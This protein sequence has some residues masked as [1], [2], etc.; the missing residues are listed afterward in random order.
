MAVT[1]L[2]GGLTPANGSDPRTFPAIWNA[3][4]DDIEQAETDI[5]TLQGDVSAIEAWDLDDINDVVITTPADGELLVYD[6]GDWVNQALTSA[7]LPAGS[8][9]QT[10]ESIS[11]VRVNTTSTSPQFLRSVTITPI[12]ATSKILLT[13]TMTL[14]IDG[15]S[16]MGQYRIYR[17]DIATGVNLAD[18]MA[19]G[20]TQLGQVG[21]TSGSFSNFTTVIRAI[22]TPGTTSAITYTFSG[23]S[24]FGGNVSFCVGNNPDIF[25]A[26]E[27]AV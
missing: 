3:T 21:R 17:G 4:A 27:V 12:S 22:D 13:A 15:G 7:Q 19:S 5:A 26:I 16:E 6:D 24:T 10:V 25:S 11:D 1:R 23:S 9:L 20:R 14:Q 8:I 18:E 2:S